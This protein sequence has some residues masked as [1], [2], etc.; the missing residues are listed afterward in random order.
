MA[1]KKNE[2]PHKITPKV[3]KVY[4]VD[5]TPCQACP[6]WETSVFNEV[7]RSQIYGR[8]SG[9]IPILV[10]CNKLGGSEIYE[11]RVLAGEAGSIYSTIL[12]DVGI[13]ENDIYTTSVVRC[14]TP[15]NRN[16]LVDEMDKCQELHGV[17]DFPEKPPKVVVV[18]GNTPLKAILDLQKITDK[19]GLFYDAELNG[20]KVKVMVTFDPASVMFDPSKLEVIKNDFRKVQDFLGNTKR[21]SLPPIRREFINSKKRFM[22]WMDYL[23]AHPKIDLNCDVETSGLSFFKDYIGAMGTCFHLPIKKDDE[24]SNGVGPLM[25]LAFMTVPREGYWYADLNDLEIKEKLTQVLVTHKLEWQGGNFDCKFFWKIG[26]QVDNDFDTIDAHVLFHEKPPHGLKSLVKN[27]LPSGGGYEAMVQEIVG[28][29]ESG[30]YLDVPVELLLEYNIDDVYYA[31]ILR[32]KFGDIVDKDGLTPFF[33]QHQMPTKRAF[34]KI[35]YRGFMVDRERVDKLSIKYR[36]KIKETQAKLFDACGHKFVWK[37]ADELAGYLYKDL[38]LEVINRTAKTGAPATDKKTLEELY[39]QTK[40]PAINDVLDMKHWG[41]MLRDY[42]DGDDGVTE[43]KD[44]KKETGIVRWMD[45]NDRVHVNLMTHGT[46][47]GR[48]AGRDPALLTVVKDPEIRSCYMAPPGWKLLDLDYTQAELVVL[49]YLAQDINMIKAVNTGDLHAEVAAGFMKN[50]TVHGDVRTSAKKTN[51]HKVYGGGPFSLSKML[52]LEVE[53]VEEWFRMWDEMFPMVPVWSRDQRQL[54]RQDK[55]IEG[56]YGRKLHFPPAVTKKIESYFD[57]LCVNWQCQNGVADTT[58]RA[59]Y[60][61]DAILDRIYGW[62]VRNI[63][64]RPGIVLTMYDSIMIE[65]PDYL[66]DE[67]RELTSNV[68]K[69]PIPKLGCVLRHDCDISQRWYENKAKKEDE[70]PQEEAI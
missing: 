68:M 26:I 11:D 2:Q 7:R 23:L 20:H 38:N 31:K 65:T 63:Y 10:Y 37:K 29:S 59:V 1:N 12:R 69:L 15:G 50:A 19:R 52:G 62:D 51:F 13:E 34:T 54:W 30:S 67:I 9:K 22:I 17:K 18:M 56:I 47:S 41:K 6:I 32:N 8:G 3:N 66:V 49:A 60:T 14:R 27:Y 55:V 45:E 4:A 28:N 61:L 42:L 35:S 70:I 44:K 40:N 64:E 21:E 24:H 53:E 39:D 58:N 46:L 48:P 33:Y 43:D 16:P 25:G 57:R 36:D 5:K